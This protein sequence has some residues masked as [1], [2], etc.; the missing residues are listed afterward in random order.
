[1]TLVGNKAGKK[2]ILWGPLLKISA[3]FVPL[4][5][6]L[7]SLAYFVFAGQWNPLA[8]W[9]GLAGGGVTVVVLLFA[10][11]FTPVFRLPYV[12]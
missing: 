6:G 8:A 12:K 4:T 3:L 5:T 9:L 7:V 1:M 11:L 2:K 10:N